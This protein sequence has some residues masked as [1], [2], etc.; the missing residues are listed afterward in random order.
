[1]LTKR[2]KIFLKEEATYN[3]YKNK[4]NFY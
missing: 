2:Y 4:L 1:M 3:I